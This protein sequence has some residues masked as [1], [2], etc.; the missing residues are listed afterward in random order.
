MS[1]QSKKQESIRAQTGTTLTYEGDWHALFTLRSIAA[2]TFNGR[3]LA[4]INQKLAQSY[5]NLPQAQQALATAN[6]AYN[7]DCLGNF[8]AT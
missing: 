1:N 3:L 6:S 4:Y 2:G 7:W 8:D 5:T